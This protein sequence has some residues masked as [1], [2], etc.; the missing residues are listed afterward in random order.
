M[1]RIQVLFEAKRAAHKP[2]YIAYLTMG[3]PTLRGSFSAAE[4]LLEEG[5]DIL[6]LGV[7]CAKPYLDGPIIRKASSLALANGTTLADILAEIPALRA[8]HPATPL[9]LF[10]YLD[11]VDTYGLEKFAAESVRVGVDAVLIPDLKDERRGEIL[12]V[13]RLCGL[14]LV[15]LVGPT[16]DDVHIQECAAG[17]NDSFVYAVTMKGLTGQHLTLSSELKKRL[18]TIKKLTSLPVVAGFGIRTREE[19]AHIAA[20]CDG[21]VIGSALVERFMGP[22]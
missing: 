7:P 22:S 4:T 9:V 10:S 1:N 13:L 20:H 3:A 19:G 18:E 2:V 8:K 21:F 11:S 15:P 14:T 12:R 6:E 17:M 5:V 16:M